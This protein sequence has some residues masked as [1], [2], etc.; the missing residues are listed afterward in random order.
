MEG[1]LDPGV[2]VI[3][4]QHGVNSWIVEEVSRRLGKQ[5]GELSACRHGRNEIF[6]GAFPP[7]AA[8]KTRE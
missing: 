6:V 7:E 1:S 8:S 3:S 5:R 4:A 2:I